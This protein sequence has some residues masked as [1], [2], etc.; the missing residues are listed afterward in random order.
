MFVFFY[1][2]NFVTIFLTVNRMG[3]QYM[4]EVAKTRKT[5]EGK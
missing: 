4:H 3:K 2:L 5:F 1:V